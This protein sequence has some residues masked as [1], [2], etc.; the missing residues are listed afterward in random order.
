MCIFTSNLVLNN[1]ENCAACSVFC[2]CH[3][4]ILEGNLTLVSL[5]RPR[6]ALPWPR[7]MS[8]VLTNNN[9]KIEKKKL[10]NTCYFT[11]DSKRRQIDHAVMKA[12]FCY[13]IC[14]LK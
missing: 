9:I 13:C 4:R 2:F 7:E 6:A 12:L 8:F 3:S 14:T 1:T 11:V 5:E 10:M